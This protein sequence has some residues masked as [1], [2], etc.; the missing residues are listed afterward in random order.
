MKLNKPK[1]F[2][3]KLNSCL[4]VHYLHEISTDKS[5]T[6]VDIVVF[7]SEFCGSAF[8]IKAIHNTRKLKIQF[9]KLNP[10]ILQKKK[11]TT[12]QNTHLLAHIVGTFHR[13]VIDKVL[14][15]PLPN[16]KFS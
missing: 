1:N 9:I 16:P 8:E 6:N 7:R 11:N 14:V 10:I 3:K 2:E 13:A 12:I 15:T 4:T 5:F